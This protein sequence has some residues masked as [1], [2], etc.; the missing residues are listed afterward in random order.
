MRVKGR[1]MWLT[2]SPAQVPEVAHFGIGAN[3]E[4]LPLRLTIPA[5]ARMARRAWSN[6]IKPSSHLRISSFVVG[7]SLV[8]STA[9]NASVR[10]ASD[11]RPLDG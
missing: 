10:S 7:L 6:V 5:L 3:N 11:V 1:P 9:I 8:L 2:G 4:S